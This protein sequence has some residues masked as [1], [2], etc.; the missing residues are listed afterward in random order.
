[1]ACEWVAPVATATTA[2]AVGVAG[3][4][5]TYFTGGKRLAHEQ[6]LAEEAREQQRLENAYVGLLDMTERAGQWAQMAYP[7]MD[8]GTPVPKLPE[9]PEQARVEA[10]VKAFGSDGVRE[11]MESWRTVV[12]QMTKTARLIELEDKGQSIP[13]AGEKSARAVFDLELRAQERTTREAIADQVA[14]ELG[15][16]TDAAG[17]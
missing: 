15:H 6:L 4:L 12:H 17:K 1:M 3:I 16:R 9:L 7:F 14:V 2:I 5:A 11:R 8:E 10:L 13:Q